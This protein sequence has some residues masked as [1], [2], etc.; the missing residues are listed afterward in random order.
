MKDAYIVQEILL[1]FPQTLAI[2]AFGSRVQGG[3]NAASDL[4]LAILVPTY[5]DQVC[6]WELSSDLANVMGYEVDLLDFRA[7]STVMQHQ[8]LTTGKHLWTA[9]QRAG[10]YEAAVLTEMIHLNTARSKLMQDITNSGT[11]YGR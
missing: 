1:R 3:Y 5:A 6:L 2:Y 11:V 9:D 10:L 4:D 7:A 8:I